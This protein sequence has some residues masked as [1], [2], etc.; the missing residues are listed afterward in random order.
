M[1]ILKQRLHTTLFLSELEREV[2]NMEVSTFCL[3][4]QDKV[5]CFP[6]TSQI[7]DLIRASQASQE[8]YTESYEA[9]MRIEFEIEAYF[10]SCPQLTVT[11]YV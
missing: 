1:I 11:A 3:H 7:T 10:D 5:T 6:V 8:G 4:T 2:N 9:L